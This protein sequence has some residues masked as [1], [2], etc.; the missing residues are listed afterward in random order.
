MG[1]FSDQNWGISVIA[2]INTEEF[3]N[4]LDAQVVLEDWRTEYNTYRP[5]QSLAGLTPAAYWTHP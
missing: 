1:N 4:L 3:A 2:V 5:H